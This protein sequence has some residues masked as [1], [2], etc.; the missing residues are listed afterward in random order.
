MTTN[1]SPLAAPRRQLSSI[2]NTAP[3]QQRVQNIHSAPSS[4]S[5]SAVGLASTAPR[6]GTGSPGSTK[7]KIATPL[8][9]TG[10]AT[11]VP[12]RRPQYP[13]YQLTGSSRLDSA[14][15]N[16]NSN[17]YVTSSHHPQYQQQQQQQG[18]SSGLP[19]ASPGSSSALKPPPSHHARISA[20][21]Q[22]PNRQNGPR[23]LPMAGTHTNTQTMNAHTQLGAT[24]TG[25]TATGV[26]GMTGTTGATGMTDKPKSRKKDKPP[27]LPPPDVISDNNLMIRYVRGPSL[28]EVKHRSK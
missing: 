3:Q 14:N 28:G 1:S 16:T 12:G 11:L 8:T 24:T 17:N 10:T 26:T 4:S 20:L 27:R 5:S 18:V 2:T 19:G 21:Q 6:P 23:G 9:S 13:Q 22:Q 7:S 15:T 25:V